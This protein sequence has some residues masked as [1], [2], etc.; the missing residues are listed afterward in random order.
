MSAPP[1]RESVPTWKLHATL[2]GVS[3]R[4][5]DTITMLDDLRRPRW[6]VGEPSEFRLGDHLVGYAL[7]NPRP[8]G[9]ALMIG[10]SRFTWQEANA[11]SDWIQM[12]LASSEP[13]QQDEEGQ[14]DR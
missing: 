10:T 5:R 3:D 8:N 6:K 13:S 14:P 12:V 4:L 11:L 7:P 2:E 1:I 9:W